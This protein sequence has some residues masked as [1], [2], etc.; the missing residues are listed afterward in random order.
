V[1]GA[2]KVGGAATAT[3]VVATVVGTGSRDSTAAAG[4]C[5]STS[6]ASSCG[7]TPANGSRSSTSVAGCYGSATAAAYRTSTAAERGTAAAATGCG[8]VAPAALCEPPLATVAMLTAARDAL[9]ERRL[10]GTTASV[11]STLAGA[12]GGAVDGT[13]RA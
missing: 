10:V 9:D 13:L 5:G 12:R 6:A 7:S 3:A 1:A 2:G 4:C 11:L 8:P